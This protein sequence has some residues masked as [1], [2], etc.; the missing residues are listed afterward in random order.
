MFKLFII[1][2]IY[3]FIYFILSLFKEDNTFSDARVA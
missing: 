2:A 1:Q 3:L